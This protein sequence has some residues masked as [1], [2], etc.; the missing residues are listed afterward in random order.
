MYSYLSGRKQRVKIGSVYSNWANVNIGVPQGSV[1]GPIIFNIFINDIFLF[2][3]DT[4][5]CN[6]A[7]DQSLYAHG[8]SIDIVVKKL[9]RD[10]R[11]VLN[12][13][14][15]N[16]L[17]PNP[18]KFQFMLLGTKSKQHLCLNINGVTTISTQSVTLLG[19]IIDWKLTFN[20]HANM[21]CAKANSKVGAITRLRFKLNT[22]QKVLLYS[23]FILGQFGY[24]TNVWAFHGKKVQERINKIQKRSLRA[25]YNDFSLDLPQLLLRGNHATIHVNNIRRLIVKVF[26]C[27][28]GEGPE[29]LD[30]I[31]RRANFN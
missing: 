28:N 18:K 21:I 15:N 25:V 6:F 30:N 31:F 23:S 7:D 29:I 14:D 16:S 22:G 17:V 11:V 2:V 5:I 9:E 8:K 4:K 13:L 1:L 10:V 27:L 26:K 3:Y 20:M 19:V 24:C 12:W